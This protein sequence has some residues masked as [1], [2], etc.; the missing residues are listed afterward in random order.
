MD[1]SEVKRTLRHLPRTTRALAEK[2][3]HGSLE[4]LQRL[5]SMAHELRP[6]CT[7]ILPVFFVH[8]DPARIPEQI[9]PEVVQDIMRAKWSLIGLAEL[10]HEHLLE[11][12]TGG[13]LCAYVASKW[14]LLY[15]WIPF[16][17]HHFLADTPSAHSSEIHSLV[18]VT[19]A[20]KV[21]LEPMIA[22]CRTP[23]GGPALAHSTIAMHETLMQ[24]WIIVGNLEERDITPQ[25][26]RP[27]NEIL[28]QF[29][30]S[31][32]T[33]VRLFFVPDVPHSKFIQAAGGPLIVVSTL[34]KYLRAVAA[35][36]KRA[37]KSFDPDVVSAPHADACFT[38]VLSSSFS[39]CVRTAHW[40][41]RND[42]FIQ[43]A[44]ISR[45]SIHTVATCIAQLWPNLVRVLDHVSQKNMNE[46]RDELFHGYDYILFA[47]LYADD[48]VAITCEALNSRLLESILQTVPLHYGLR[49]ESFWQLDVELLSRIPTLLMFDRVLLAATKSLSRI[50]VQH[51]DVHARCDLALWNGWSHFRNTV[52]WYAAIKERVAER[53]T[54]GIACC[55]RECKVQEGDF[56]LFR[57]SGCLLTKYCSKQ[58]QRSDWKQRHRTL[59]SFLKKAVPRLAPLIFSRPNFH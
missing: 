57:C 12:S 31:A 2:A 37:R 39:N 18:S 40:I 9:T 35:E 46:G 5:A 42:D 55:G 44:L 49:L 53:P 13:A 17:Y 6:H 48:P 34:L 51:I 25:Y 30:L 19:E 16:F 11:A 20:L 26:G 8:I 43:E 41:S 14:N 23:T 32:S 52:A 47:I 45:R 15:R 24:L 28:A 58:C 33:I 22:L 1:A 56:E 36:L 4:H 27:S 7:T 59:C 50:A 3:V 10:L 38:F 29:R 54:Y 21:T